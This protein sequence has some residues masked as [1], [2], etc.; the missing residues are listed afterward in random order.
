MSILPIIKTERL[1]LRNISMG[2]VDDMYEY[3]KTNLVGPTAGWKPHGSIF[4]TKSIIASFIGNQSRGDLGVWAIVLKET[5]KM[6]G[7][8]QTTK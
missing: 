1:I 8:I 7:T 3:S 5:G 6:I 4:E 2:D